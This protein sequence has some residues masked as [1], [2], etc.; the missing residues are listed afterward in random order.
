M[1]WPMNH[2]AA[3]AAIVLGAMVFLLPSGATAASVTWLDEI[4]GLVMEHRDLARFEA[5]EGAYDPYLAQ[6]HLVR[7]ALA[8]DD[9]DGTYLAMNQFM[10]MLENDP[11]GAG[12]P[13]WSAKTIF[14]FCGKVTPPD[15]HDA[16]RHAPEMTEGGFDY[17]DD[18]VFDSGA[19]G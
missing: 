10:D 13:T 12:I 2:P 11:K 17:W 3:L 6:L 7:I 1:K 16:A 5:R 4:T 14:D 15:Y 19:G 18:N 8:R 9:R